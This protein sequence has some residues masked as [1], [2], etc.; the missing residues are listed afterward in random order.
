MGV[1]T[2]KL[3]V[4]M[5]LLVPALSRSTEAAPSG[6]APTVV[7]F[8]DDATGHPS[9]SFKPVVGNWSVTDLEGARGLMVNGARRRRR[10]A[11][12]D[13][14]EQG[15][16]LYVERYAEFAHGVKPPA[17]FPLAVYQGECPS[18]DL[19]MSVSFYPK[20]GRIDQAAGL[21]WNITPNGTYLG[22]GANV[23]GDDLRFFRVVR[24]ARTILDTVPNV[25]ITSGTWHTL[26]VA[27]HGRSLS[28][29]IDGQ[30]RL[31]REVETPPTGGCG[32]WSS[33][34]SEVLFDDFKVGKAP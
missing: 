21:A 26:Q 1:N 14:V 31:K 17:Y 13:L 22:A 16:T 18:D 19:A 28:V 4:P 25:Q 3:L 15:R 34:D 27:L 24:G 30:E 6:P 20:G 11:S 32:L 9:P 5:L 7:T 12:A 2:L 29:S 33:G 23:R 10:T 8:D